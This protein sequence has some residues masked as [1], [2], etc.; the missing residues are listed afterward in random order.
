MQI[1]PLV[2]NTEDTYWPETDSIQYTEEDNSLSTHLL[3]HMMF[4]A[5]RLE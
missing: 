2:L 5:Y 4:S 3:V 1:F